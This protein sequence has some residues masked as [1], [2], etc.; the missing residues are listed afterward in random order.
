[1][2]VKPAIHRIDK[3][4]QQKDQ[5]DGRKVDPAEVGEDVGQ[6]AADGTQHRL[7]QLAE[8]GVDALHQRVIAVHNVEPDEHIEHQ[9]HD[10]CEV[11]ERNNIINEINEWVKHEQ[12]LWLQK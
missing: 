7:E 12:F 1:M 2:P 3:E 4:V 10:Q 11:D 9:P 8:R 5:H 6:H